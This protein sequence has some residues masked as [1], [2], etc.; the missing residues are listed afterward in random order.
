MGVHIFKEDAAQIRIAEVH[1]TARFKN[2]LAQHKTS[3]RFQLKL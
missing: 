3:F 1:K 2:L